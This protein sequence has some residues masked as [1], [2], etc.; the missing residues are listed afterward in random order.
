MV[1]RMHTIVRIYS[2]IDLLVG[3]LDRLGK[4]IDMNSPDLARSAY[5]SIDRLTF[6]EVNFK[7]INR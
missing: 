4:D 7:S 5:L 1:Q 3:E 6:H 2:R